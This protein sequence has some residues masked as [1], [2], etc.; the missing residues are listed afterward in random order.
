MKTF[1]SL[2]YSLALLQK[3]VVGAS[4]PRHFQRFPTTRYQLNATQVQREL[5]NQISNTTV[6]FGPDDSRYNESTARWSIFAKPRIQIVVEPGQASDVS[7]IVS[8]LSI[9]IQTYKLT[10]ILGQVL[11]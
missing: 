2:V 7:Q 6:I 4:I 10:A 8:A 11:Q 1:V 9:T 3:L 5:G